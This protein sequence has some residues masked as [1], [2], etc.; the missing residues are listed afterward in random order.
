M[1]LFHGG[2][3]TRPPKALGPSGTLGQVIQGSRHVC[4]RLGQPSL[5]C[6]ASDSGRAR[7]PSAPLDRRVKS[8]TLGGRGNVSVPRW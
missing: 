5:P 1:C 7:W 8:T 6:A 2:K 3:N 4:G